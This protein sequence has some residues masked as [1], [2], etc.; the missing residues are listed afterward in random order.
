MPY[1]EQGS[2]GYRN[3]D[4][5]RDAASEIRPKAA[6]IRARVM[7]LLRS[8]TAARPRLSELRNAGSVKDSGDRHVS[9]FGKKIIAWVAT[10]PRPA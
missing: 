10:E 5:S 8:P 9:R 4:T 6:T 1:T 2:V 7:A 3:T